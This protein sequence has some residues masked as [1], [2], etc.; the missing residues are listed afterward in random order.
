MFYSSSSLRRND[1]VSSPPKNR[2][3]ETFLFLSKKNPDLVSPVSNK[4]FSCDISYL[5]EKQ[6][7]LKKKYIVVIKGL[8]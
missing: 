7:I 6:C 5:T 8:E 4:L 1:S 2:T 3:N